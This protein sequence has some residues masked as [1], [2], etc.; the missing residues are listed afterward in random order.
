MPLVS[1]PALAVSAAPSAN[2]KAPRHGVQP[3]ADPTVDESVAPPADEKAP[4]GEGQPSADP[5]L[6]EP[7]VPSAG[8]TAPG[9]EALSVAEPTDDLMTCLPPH[10][11]SSQRR[12][13]TGRLLPHPLGRRRRDGLALPQ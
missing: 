1:A 4:K 3:V 7:A 5:T 12:L 10:L 11:L 13:W 6:E 9:E 8:E 2:D